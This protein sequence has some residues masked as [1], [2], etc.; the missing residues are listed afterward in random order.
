[1]VPSRHTE[2]FL[3][4]AVCANW[5]VLHLVSV[6]WPVL[7]LLACVDLFVLQLRVSTGL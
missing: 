7:Q 2:E 4:A 5:P 3:C 1:M 6:G